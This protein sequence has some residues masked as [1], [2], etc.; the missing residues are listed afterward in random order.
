M[1]EGLPEDLQ[2]QIASGDCLLVVGA[3][4]AI[5]GTGNAPCASWNGLLR[6]GV[7]HCPKHLPDTR[8]PC[9]ERDFPPWG[10]WESRRG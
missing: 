1:P 4:V 10:C 7:Q 6:H 9:V 5:F 3:G 2:Q 8:F